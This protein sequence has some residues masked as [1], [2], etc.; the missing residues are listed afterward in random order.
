MIVIW[1]LKCSG[2]SGY[3][4]QVVQRR[5]SRRR[6]APP[7]HHDP[8]P[9]PVPTPQL[10][11][12]RQWGVSVGRAHVCGPG[13]TVT[14]KAE[15]LTETQALRPRG[16]GMGCVAVGH[17]VTEWGR[18]RQPQ[19]AGCALEEDFF[20]PNQAGDS[21]ARGEGTGMAAEGAGTLPGV[22]GRSG[23]SCPGVQAELSLIPSGGVWMLSLGG[24]SQANVACV[25]LFPGALPR[26]RGPAPPQGPGALSGTGLGRMG[27][28]SPTAFTL[29][30]LGKADG[31]GRPQS[32]V[33]F[34]SE[35]IRLTCVEPPTPPESHRAQ[36]LP[37]P[38]S[39]RTA[40]AWAW[41][42]PGLQGM[43]RCCWGQVRCLG[44]EPSSQPLHL[45][46]AWEAAIPS[47]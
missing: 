22:T 43:P 36:C 28:M 30:P 6:G 17:G 23:G 19:T 8:L 24:A 14:H 11:S 5:H 29:G 16:V 33:A 9:R 39:C 25:T 32:Q 21:G 35:H 12:Q 20:P 4:L 3:L 31:H 34:G 26:G 38:M 13:L 7:Q 37:G 47:S 42:A 44:G 2:P 40:E 46:R 15:A 41:L 27:P 18:G 10:C 1:Y 45:G